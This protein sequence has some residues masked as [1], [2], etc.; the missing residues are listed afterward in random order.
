MCT[1]TTA[2]KSPTQVNLGRA[3]PLR[4]ERTLIGC[5]ATT[6]KAI[7][8]SS[9]VCF[10]ASRSRSGCPLC[11]SNRPVA[12]IVGRSAQL[13][14]DVGVHGGNVRAQILEGCN[15]GNRDQAGNQGVFDRVR[16]AFIAQQAV[17]SGQVRSLRSP[18]EYAP[19]WLR[20]CNGC[21]RVQTMMRLLRPKQKPG[22][23]GASDGRFA[24]HVSGAT[25]PDRVAR[26]FPALLAASVP[27]PPPL[28][29]R[30]PRS[31]ARDAD[32]RQPRP[33]VKAG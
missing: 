19:E 25:V 30:R 7:D 26:F 14:R 4:A 24:A 12:R 1:Y 28:T 5:G 2:E 18:R 21:P 11:S 29:H 33:Q 31:A 15:R 17:E 3:V 13:I 10:V 16:A 20:N 23:E 8:R 6:V 22:R 32:P 9:R 27:A